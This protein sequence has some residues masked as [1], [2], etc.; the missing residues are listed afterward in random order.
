MRSKR[1]AILRGVPGFC[2]GVVGSTISVVKH[3][4]TNEACEKS[5]SKLLSFAAR[6]RAA[7]YISQTKQAVFRYEKHF[8]R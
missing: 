8:I 6:T 4:N 7:K 5:R 3:L 1:A 2:F